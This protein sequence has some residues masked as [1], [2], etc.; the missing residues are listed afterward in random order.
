MT[1]FAII[2]GWGYCLCSPSRLVQASSAQA[3]H[4][5]FRSG[6]SMGQTE[7]STQACVASCGD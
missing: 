1:S 3:S 7:A 4:C 2:V 5:Y 6:C